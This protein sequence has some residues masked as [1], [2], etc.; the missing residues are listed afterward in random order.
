MF[1]LAVKWDVGIVSDSI[2]TANLRVNV[3]GIIVTCPLGSVLYLV[4]N[5]L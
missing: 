3:K 2:D 1:N 4:L 5:I